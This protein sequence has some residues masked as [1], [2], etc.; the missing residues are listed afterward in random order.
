MQ[1]LA[2]NAHEFWHPNEKLRKANQKLATKSELQK[3]K[4]VL[5]MLTSVKACT[6]SSCW[7]II[8]THKYLPAFHYGQIEKT[9]YWFEKIWK[10]FSWSV[11]PDIHPCEIH[12]AECWWML[13]DNHVSKFNDHK[14]KTFVP[15]D[16]I[17]I[18]KSVSKWYEAGVFDQHWFAKLYCNG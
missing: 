8:P 16:L 12:S 15:L 2:L 9:C 3:F 13:V 5:I 18:D 10:H 17:Y 1:P 4:G 11:Q 6:C 7:D 14:A